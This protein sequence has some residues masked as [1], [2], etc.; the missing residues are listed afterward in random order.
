MLPVLEVELSGQGVQDA[1]PPKLY[2]FAGHKEQSSFV[3]FQNEPAL[4]VVHPDPSA[5]ALGVLEGH[6]HGVLYA[7]EGCVP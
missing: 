6:M 5:S 4:H 7:L 3:E 2:V 1:A